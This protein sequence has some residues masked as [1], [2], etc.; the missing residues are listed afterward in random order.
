MPA[1]A[2][3]RTDLD[4]VKPVD[5]SMVIWGRGLDLTE[6]AL[7][8]SEGLVGYADFATRPLLRPGE[9]VEVI[10]GLVATQHSGTGKANQYF[11]RGF[12]LDHGTDFAAYFEGLPINFRTHGHG[13]GYLDLNF[14]IPELVEVVEFRKGPYY[15]DVGDFSAAGSISFKTFDALEEGF[16]KGTAGEFDFYRVVAGHSMPLAGGTLLLGGEVKFYDGPWDLDEDFEQYNGLVKF[17][18]APGDT[19]FQIIATGFHA[20]WTSTDQIPLRAVE[21]GLIDRFGFIDPDLGGETT[22]INVIGRVF[23]DALGGHLHATVYGSYYDFTLFSNFTYFANDPVNGDEF[24]QEDRRVVFGG[25]AYGEWSLSRFGVNH[26]LIAGLE[27]RFDNI[28]DVGLFNTVGRERINT[29]RSDAVDQWNVSVYGDVTSRWTRRLETTIGLRIDTFGFDVEAQI[30]DNS[31]DGTDTLVSP[32]ATLAYSLAERTRVYLNYGRGFHSNDVRGATIAVDPVTGEAVEPV[33]VLV[34]AN[35]AEIG[36]RTNAI[37]ALTV[38][39]AAFWL[40]LESELVFVGDAGTTEV[41]DGSRRFGFEFSGFWEATDWLVFDASATTTNARFQNGDRIPGAV[42]TVAALGSTVLLDN[43]FTATA[44][45]RHF[46]SAPLIEDNSTRSEATTLVNAGI[47]YR[48][49]AF[50]ARLDVFNLFDAQDA[51]ITYFFESQLPG[52]AAPVEDIHFH[53]VEPRAV[54]GS[55][56]VRF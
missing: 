52:E 50:E 48:F 31:G 4:K 12:N 8:A 20:D 46:S 14:I 40:E 55:L 21:S 56:T 18:S 25:D 39:L 16:I 15:A 9:L 44:R 10:P 11:L 41:N 32:K 36:L 27:S 17:T 35:G 30:D 47:G 37:P 42:P 23:A 49:G 13:Q 5:E 1:L 26:Q 45:M 43:G 19:T 54:R 51:D 6:T 38:T 3:I 33:D 34:P 24:E 28:F 7:S 53:P 2:D 29:V 22:R